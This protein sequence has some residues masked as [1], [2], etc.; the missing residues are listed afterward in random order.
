MRAVANVSRRQPFISPTP[1]AP[2]AY[3]DIDTRDGALAPVATT[4]Q[5]VALP[6]PAPVAYERPASRYDWDVDPIVRRARNLCVC[7]V[8]G[9][10]ILAFFVHIIVICWRCHTAGTTHI[11][12][13]EKVWERVCKPQLIEAVEVDLSQDETCRIAYEASHPWALSHRMLACAESHLLGGLISIGHDT[14][15]RALVVRSVHR[16]LD[17]I[18]FIFAIAFLCIV[19]PLWASAQQLRAIEIIRATQSEGLLGSKH[20]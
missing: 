16:I 9:L 4:S 13:Q 20:R 6:M 10:V 19:A 8:C 1:E 15:I 14:E 2:V 7:V 5:S 3:V 12:T 17:Y 18:W 11:T